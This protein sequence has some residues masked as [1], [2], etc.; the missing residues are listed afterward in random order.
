M[1]INITIEMF[2][3][4]GVYYEIILNC[5]V[6]WSS[7]WKSRREI[8]DVSYCRANIIGYQNLYK[9]LSPHND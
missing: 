6:T 7:L 3:N 4:W 1:L 2:N 8:M 9:W 5:F